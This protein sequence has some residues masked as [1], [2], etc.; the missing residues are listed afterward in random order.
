[1][2]KLLLIAAFV[3]G[4]LLLLRGRRTPVRQLVQRGCTLLA[5]CL[6]ALAVVFPNLVTRVAHLVGVG[7]G[8]DLV[9]YL[10]CVAFLYVTIALYQRIGE[11]HERNVELARQLALHTADPFRH[12]DGSVEHAHITPTR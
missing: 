4:A 10:L 5:I 11:L 1:M 7:R 8:T 12:L 2:I 6:G 9:L 3:G